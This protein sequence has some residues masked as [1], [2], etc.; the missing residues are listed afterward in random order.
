MK[1][2]YNYPLM[3][4]ALEYF[5]L[6]PYSEIYLREY[7]RETGISINSAQRFLDYFLKERLL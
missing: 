2:R 4:K 3:L 7:A 5:V 6:N 1:K